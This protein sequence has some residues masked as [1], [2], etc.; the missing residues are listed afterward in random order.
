[1]IDPFTSLAFST[2]S[3]KGVYALLLGSGISRS[4]RIPTGWEVTKDLI[5][6]LA[7]LESEDCEPDPAAWFK[8]KFG[9]APDYSNLLD[10]IAKTPSERQQLLRSYFEP[11]P[12]ELE[13]G[14]KLPSAAQK[15]IAQLAASGY[16]RVIL[17]TNFDRLTERALEEVGISPTVISTTD[18]IAGA[19]PLVH[20]GITV[21]KV[22]GDYL[23][24]RI[25][26]TEPELASYDEAMDTLLDRIFDEYGLIVCGWSA[27]WDVALRTALERCSSRRFTTYW[28]TRSALVGTAERLASHR[29][30]EVIEIAGADEF[31]SGLREK[32]QALEDMNAPHPLSAKMA[33]AMMKRYLVDPSAH[34]KLHD[35]ILGETQGGLKFQVQ[36][37]DG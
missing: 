12:E 3:N 13:E 31:F 30:A 36:R 7:K 9:V 16:L 23:D 8:T 17:T 24:S 28:A 21:I 15:A 32:V 6:K 26:N 2:Y 14:L 19:L 34:I 1:M 27:D 4:A 35:L 20:S 18:Q 33:V 25:R 22:N 10:S 29:R 11:T 37:V 5:K